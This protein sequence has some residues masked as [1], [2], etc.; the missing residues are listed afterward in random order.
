L[1]LRSVL[2]AIVQ[3]FDVGFVPGETNEDFGEQ[4]LDTFI[5]T[6]PSLTLRLTPRAKA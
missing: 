5:I 6:L 1:T 4:F 3:N 2:S